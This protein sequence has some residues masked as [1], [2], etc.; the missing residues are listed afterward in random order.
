M[1]PTK[2]SERMDK[3]WMRVLD[4][5]NDPIFVHDK[6]FHIVRCNKAYQQHAGIPLKQIIGKLYFEIFPKM[7]TSLPG[8]SAAIETPQQTEVDE[9]VSV[10][11]ATFLSRSYTVHD[12]NGDYLYSMH[13]L[14]DITER[15]QA[16]NALRES[17]ELLRR[18]TDSARD[19]IITVAGEQG[20][21]TVWNPAAE[22]IFGYS[23]EEMVGQALH[24]IIVAPAFRETMALSLTHFAK[25]GEGAAVG[26]TL[27]LVALHKNGTEFPIEVSLSATQLRGKWYATGIARDI[28]ER[29][30]SELSLNH[31]NRALAA[32]GTVNRQ[33]VYSTSEGELLQSIC[34][35]IVVQK[36]YRMAVVVYVQEDGDKDLK[37][38]A[39]AGNAEDV[40]EATQIV[41]AQSE[42]NKGPIGT[43][44]DSKETQVCQDIEAD[45]R[46]LLWRDM[47]LKYGNTSCITLPLLNADN[48]VFGILTVFSDEKNTFIPAEID[49]LEEM[50][51][52][53]AF[54]VRTLRVRH[55]RDHALEQ[56]QAQL[57]KL[58]ENLGDTVKAIASIVE[59]RDPYTSG[60]QAR[61]ASLAVAMA[62]QM[63]LPDE[64]VY[65]IHLAGVVHDLGKIQVPAEILSKPTRLNEYEYSLIK[66]HPKAGYEILKGIDF[67]WPVAL[68]VLQHHE[69]FDGSG[70][71]QG[72]K[73]DEIL[74]D[75]RILCVADVVE[76]M[77][78]HRPYRAGLGIGAALEEIEAGKGTL[79]DP[80]VAEACMEVFR[81]GQF[82]F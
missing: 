10:G 73:G 31:A 81:E 82:K 29:K 71:P 52:D 56:N 49:L 6:E 39:Q 19:A 43:V 72:L 80:V 18:M 1:A 55:E 35:A 14:E 65:G 16:E 48:I 20:L 70:Y 26:K 68:A 60:H 78:S 64:Q 38:M 62:K 9:E 32:L 11:E 53:M 76:A 63:G 30:Q 44:I 59:M 45:P 12:D 37:V 34:K 40:Q 69:R 3:E 66:A 28:S 61:V 79:Y 51:A 57:Q 74:L 42:R 77:A 41:L 2:K 17:E 21:V 4:V 58:E 33:L 67:S 22:T 7:Q 23:K 5:V 36:G 25:T 24:E 47:A 27:E 46:Y 15:R 54:G 8:C 50:A 13:I 75:A